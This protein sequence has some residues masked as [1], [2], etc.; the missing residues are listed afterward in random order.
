MLASGQ[1]RRPFPRM[2]LLLLLLLLLLQLWLLLLLTPD[3]LAPDSAT[4]SSSPNVSNVDVNA[5]VQDL[6]ADEDDDD[7]DDDVVVVVAV[8]VVGVDVRN[9]R[10]EDHIVGSSTAV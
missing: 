2:K 5:C 1:L 8:A 7:N 3:F 4:T 9:E 6:T 10:L